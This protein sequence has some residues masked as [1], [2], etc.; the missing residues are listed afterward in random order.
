[1]AS[2]L[3]TP[4]GFTGIFLLIVGIL[5]TVGGIIGLIVQSNQPKSWWVWFLIFAGIVLGIL[6]AVLLAIALSQTAV[7]V[8]PCGQVVAAPVPVMYQQPTPIMVAPP[9]YVAPLAPQYVPAPQPIYQQVA[10][11]LPAANLGTSIY[12][13]GHPRFN[14]DPVDVFTPFPGTRQRAFVKGPYGPNGEE[15]EVSGTLTSAPIATKRTYD[16]PDHQVVVNQR[17]PQYVAG[18]Q[19][20]YIAAPPGRYVGAPPPRYAAAPVPATTR[21]YAAESEN[22]DPAPQRVTTVSPG[23]PQSVNA[24]GP[25]GLGG[26]IVQVPGTYTPPATVTETDYDIPNHRVVSNQML[27]QYAAP[28]PMFGNYATSPSPYQAIRTY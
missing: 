23:V 25:Y 4:L 24:V 12:T 13:T 19:A 2:R 11:P 26:Q 17:P 27:G 22:F 8:N 7:V 3:S 16:I 18:T 9:P 28:N 15:I 20:R 14:P 21:T 10:A 1:M 6:G 5:M